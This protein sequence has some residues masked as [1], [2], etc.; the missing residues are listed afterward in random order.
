MRPLQPAHFL[1]V[2]RQLLDPM[3]RASHISMVDQPV[4]RAR[5]QD[6]LVPRQRAHS[7]GMARHAAD[8]RLR[9]RVPQLDRARVGADSNVGALLNPSDRRDG[10]VA[11]CKVAQLGDFGRVSGPKVNAVAQADAKDVDVAPID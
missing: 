3:L 2:A 7:T 4:P 5:R 8:D 10:V 1:L 9:F 6:V 11:G